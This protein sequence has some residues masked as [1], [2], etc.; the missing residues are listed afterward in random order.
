MHVGHPVLLRALRHEVHVAVPELFDD[1]LPLRL[2]AGFVQGAQE[3]R[4]APRAQ[5]PDERGG[6]LAGVRAPPPGRLKQPC[7]A[8]QAWLTFQF[9]LALLA[10]LAL[11]A[12]QGRQPCRPSQGREEFLHQS[13]TYLPPI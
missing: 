8:S 6:V 1:E 5:R 3:S 13:D 2:A 4:V 12:L 10:F 9:S 7:Q 11:L